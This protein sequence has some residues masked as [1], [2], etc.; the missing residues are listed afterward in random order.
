MTRF[1]TI[2][3]AGCMALCASAAIQP[4]PDTPFAQEYRE[5]YVVDGNAEAN[6][7]RG[8]ALGEAGAVWTATKAGVYRYADGAWSSKLDTG[9]AFAAESDGTGGVWLGA[10]DGLYHGTADGALSKAPRVDAPIGAIGVSGKTVVAMGPRGMFRSEDGATWTH[11]TGSWPDSTR[12]VVIDADGTLWVPTSHGLYHLD[13]NTVLEHV[14]A[15]FDILSGEGSSAAMTVDGRLWVGSNGGLDVFDDGNRV[16]SYT[17]EQ[18]LPYTFARSVDVAPD[19]TL[20]IGTE[21]VGVTRFD[22][23]TWSLR[24]SKRWLPSDEVRGVA[25]ADD[26]TAWVATAK[27]VSAIKR[28]MMTLAEKADH[29]HGI[30]MDRKI[31]EPFIVEK[32][33]LLTPGDVSTWRTEDDDN[34]GS[35]TAMFMVAE[36]FRYQVTKDPL[37]K[38]NAEKAFDFMELLQTITETD[39]FFARTIIPTWWTDPDKNDNPHRI[40][41]RNHTHSPQEIAERNVSDPRY[42]PV[43]VR[44][45]P[46]KDGKW[47]WKGDTSSDEVV[48]HFWGFLYYYELVADTEAEKERVRVLARRIMDYIIDGGF[49]FRDTDGTHTRWGVWAPEKLHGDP[50]WQAERP[51]NATEIL[52]FLKATHHMTGDP[53]Y[54]EHYERFIEEHGYGEYARAPKPTAPSTRTD[55]DSD[56]LSMTF[57]GL[58]LP[59]GDET[60]RPLYEEGL[61]Q[62]HG[63]IAKN[64][65]PMFSFVCG[66]MGVEDFNLDASVAFLRDAPLDLIRWTVDNGKREDIGLARYPELGELQTDRLLPAS[67][68]GIMRW[69]K[70]PWSAVRGDGGRTE[71]SGVYWLLPY[72]MGRYYGFIAA[73]EG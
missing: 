67:E 8:I 6:D 43:D 22:G 70:N 59:G 71:S 60:Y 36:A 45:R 35:Y 25:F 26:G 49:V 68:R 27:G 69:D 14:H 18:G 66:A 56:L 52:S 42:K 64:D 16:A 28:R 63:Q 7:V 58:L 57:P 38:R 13:G 23:A 51:V 17:P 1:M 47:L 4:A 37:A 3:V 15:E 53:K 32:S 72:W 11:V 41:D 40:H 34:D 2:P 50:D 46:S 48:G 65:S 21:G 62:W 29:F 5:F 61:R 55:I 9:P 19:G 33:R 39:G 73:P 31:R 54:L 12:A 24:H 10:W 20:W 30:V 44:W